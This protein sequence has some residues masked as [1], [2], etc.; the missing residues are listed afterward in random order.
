M[1][2]GLCR[3][4]FLLAGIGQLTFTIRDE[5]HIGLFKALS[6]HQSDRFTDGAF[7]VGAAA[8]E[9]RS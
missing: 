9:A 5:N 7:K 1:I 2:R 8:E 6:V 3:L 4:Q